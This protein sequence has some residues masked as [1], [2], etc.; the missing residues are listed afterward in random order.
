MI[1]V[2]DN[3]D[4]FTFNLVQFVGELGADP[5]VHRN[6]ALS[7]EGAA[8]LGPRESSSRRARAR[9]RRPASPS[10]SSGGY[11]HASPSWE[12]VWATR[13]SARPSEA[14]STAPRGRSTE[15]RRR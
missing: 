12:S 1:L 11:R 5:Q 13:R 8:A 15:R 9:P 7:V 6:D 2:I 3:Y 10:T 14:G 4:S